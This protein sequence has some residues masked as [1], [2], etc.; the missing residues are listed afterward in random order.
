MSAQIE[1]LV[2]DVLGGVVEAGHGVIDLIRT[3][4]VPA[5]EVFVEPH[6]GRAGRE[7]RAG[8]GHEPGRAKEED[9]A[10]GDQN[11]AEEDEDRGKENESDDRSYAHDPSHS[12]QHGPT[13]GPSRPVRFQLLD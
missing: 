13:Q 12:K 7:S 1:R 9:E 2:L 11:W 10:E 6:D 4:G 5:F 8:G 3:R